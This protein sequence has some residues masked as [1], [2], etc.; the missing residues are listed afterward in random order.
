LHDQDEVSTLHDQ[1]KM[2]TLQDEVTQAQVIN[3]ATTGLHDGSIL[4]ALGQHYATIA[5]RRRNASAI[6]FREKG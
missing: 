6:L 1:D 5:P 4:S 3:T 2:F